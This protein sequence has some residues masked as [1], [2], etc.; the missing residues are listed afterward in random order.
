MDTEGM[1]SHTEGVCWEAEI[2]AGSPYLNRPIRTIAEAERDI[3]HHENVI[4]RLALAVAL[5]PEE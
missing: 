5:K 4:I 1:R 3:T 2:Q